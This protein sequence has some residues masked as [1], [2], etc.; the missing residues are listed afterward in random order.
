MTDNKSEKLFNTQPT[1]DLYKAI[2][3]LE[4]N[5]ILTTG[6]ADN[7]R[8]EIEGKQ[9]VSGYSKAKQFSNEQK[10]KLSKHLDLLVSANLITFER[11]SVLKLR[12]IGIT[13]TQ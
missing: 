11:A 12:K 3:E 9:L 1:Q 4:N 5:N 6:R 2:D 8:N 13:L 7:M 10:T